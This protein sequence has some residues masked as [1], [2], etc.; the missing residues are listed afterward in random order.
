MTGCV[1]ME[2]VAKIR[3]VYFF[4]CFRRLYTAT[5]VIWDFAASF[6]GNTIDLGSIRI[7]CRFSDV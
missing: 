5:G 7:V 1:G 6:D 2:V 4:D 3:N